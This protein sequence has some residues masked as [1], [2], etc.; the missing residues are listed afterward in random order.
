MKL[1]EYLEQKDITLPQ[2]CRLINAKPSHMCSIMHD[3]CRP[4]L[5]L[6]LSIQ[7]ATGG[8]VK[9]EELRGKAE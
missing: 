4:S 7:A 6:A 3:N 9:A 2:F 1:K 5:A 8:M